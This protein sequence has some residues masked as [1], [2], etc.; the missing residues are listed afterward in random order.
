MPQN[1][2]HRARSWANI[3][4]PEGPWAPLFAIAAVLATVAMV[5]QGPRIGGDPPAVPDGRPY[6]VADA[7]GA[8][9][10]AG[11]GSAPSADHR[12]SDAGADPPRTESAGPE[13]D[14]PGAERKVASATTAATGPRRRTAPASSHRKRRSAPG[15][16]RPGAGRDRRQVPSRRAVPR[17]VPATMIARTVS[18]TR[19]PSAPHRPAVVGSAEREFGAP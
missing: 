15:R 5:A 9:A 18:A 7:V 8:P 3:P 16:T 11:V 19:Q 6:A 4:L 10:P 12:S 2:G 1:H 17:P 13:P 14:P